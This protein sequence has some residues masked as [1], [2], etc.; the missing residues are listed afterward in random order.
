VGA[1]VASATWPNTLDLATSLPA[2][3][4]VYVGDEVRD[5]EA[6]RQAG[7]AVAA[8][9]WGFNDRALLARHCPDYLVERPEELLQLLG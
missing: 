3:D 9:T 1:Y 2:R 5:I 7:V 6:G 8:M 4:V